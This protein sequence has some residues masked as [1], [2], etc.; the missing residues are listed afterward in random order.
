MY[1]SILSTEDLP[2]QLRSKIIDERNKVS[3]QL[4]S[5]SINI[6]TDFTGSTDAQ[7]DADLTAPNETG[8]KKLDIYD[9]MES[10]V[11]PTTDMQKIVD[12]FNR[13]YEEHAEKLDRNT[14]RALD[15]IKKDFDKTD[16]AWKYNEE[17]IELAMRYLVLEVGYKSKTNDLFYKVLNEV[18]P[19]EVDKY[20]KRVKLFTTKNF[21]RTDEKY[22]RSLLQARTVLTI[23]GQK[24][25]K[26]EIKKEVVQCCCLE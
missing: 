2:D 8:I 19:E 25:I 5:K 10:I 16:E 22:L 18:N 24:D 1:F 17:R 23:K 3:I 6:F 11:I 15:K 4:K 12:E 20:I 26:K 21:V 7:V 14:K 13:F 9:G